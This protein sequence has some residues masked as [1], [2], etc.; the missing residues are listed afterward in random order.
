VHSVGESVAQLGGDAQRQAGFAHPAR[1]SQRQ[2][3]HFVAGQHGRGHGHLCLAPEQR[4]CRCRQEWRRVRA[5]PSEID[6]RGGGAGGGAQLSQLLGCQVQ[7][8]S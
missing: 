4:G 6:G 2:E 7:R 3:A 1:A 5:L 8:C